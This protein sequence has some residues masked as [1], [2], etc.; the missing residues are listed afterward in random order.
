MLWIVLPRTIRA[1]ISVPPASVV[2]V[3]KSIVPIDVDVVIASPTCVPTP[4]A[5]PCRSH[6]DSHTKP[7]QHSSSWIGR[8]NHGRVRII[9]RSPDRNRVIAGNVNY[10]CLGGLDH[11]DGFVLDNL[12]FDFLLLG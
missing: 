2:V 10:F 4:A 12:G 3:H 6:G 5:A 11:Y 7:K 1:T 8:I 9:W